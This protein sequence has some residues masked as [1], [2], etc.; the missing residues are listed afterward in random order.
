MSHFMGNGPQGPTL[1]ALLSEREHSFSYHIADKPAVLPTVPKTKAEEAADLDKLMV[2]INELVTKTMK[3][4]KVEFSPDEGARP[5]ADPEKK[6][7]HPYIFFDIISSVPATELKPR[8][9]E[10]F[11]ED[12]EDNRTGVIYGQTFDALVQFNILACDYLT[13]TKV[14]KALEEL[15]FTYTAYFKQ[16]GVSELIFSQRFTDKNWDMYRQSCSVRSLQYRVRYEKHHI[17]YDVNMA[18]VFIK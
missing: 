2:M 17:L 16:R 4:D 3:K 12:A 7:S 6:I 5:I 18:D 1:E 14:M 15:L 8:I 9:R 10:T 13:A 11:A